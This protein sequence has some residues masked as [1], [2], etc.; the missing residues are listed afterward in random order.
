MTSSEEDRSEE[1]LPPMAMPFPIPLTAPP[2]TATSE[3]LIE[4]VE[5]RSPYVSQFTREDWATY[6]KARNR[7]NSRKTYK[8]KVENEDTGVLARLEF[9]DKAAVSI[10]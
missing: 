8:A 2:R 9:S 4:W 7:K 3:E 1:N 6:Q 10:L 5:T